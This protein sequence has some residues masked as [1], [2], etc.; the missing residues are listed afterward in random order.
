M[1]ISCINFEDN[2]YNDINFDITTDIIPQK[3]LNTPITEDRIKSQ[4]MKTN[5]TPYEFKNIA[6]YINI[7]G[8]IDL[9]TKNK[10]SKFERINKSP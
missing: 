8:E 7:S 5:N 4:I 3:A 10:I 2:F 1:H 6:V 9:D